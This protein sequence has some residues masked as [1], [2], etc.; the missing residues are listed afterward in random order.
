MLCNNGSEASTLAEVLGRNQG[1]TRPERCEIDYV[2]L[3]DGSRRHSRVCRGMG[4]PSPGNAGT[5]AEI[6]AY[7][8]KVLG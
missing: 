2:V 5:F 6:L 8:A 4:R 1:P 3:A 7:R